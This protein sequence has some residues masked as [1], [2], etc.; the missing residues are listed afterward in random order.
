MIRAAG[1]LL[2]MGACVL[3]LHAE[4]FATLAVTT[5]DARGQVV[6]ANIPVTV[7]RPP[8][9]G[10]FP[11]VILSHGRPPAAQRPR[12]GRVKLSSVATTFLGL[13]MVVIVPTRIGYGAAGGPDVEFSVS[14]EEPK[15]P[16]ALGAVADQIGSA[17]SY[18]RSLSYVDG[19]Q[20]FLVGH[21]VG[22]AG[23]VAAAVRGF[24]GVRAAVNFNGG[25]GG[26][27]GSHPGEPCGTDVLRKTFGDLGGARSTVPL[28]WVHTEN[29]ELISMRYAQEWFAAFT[30]AGGRGTFTAFPAH[31]DGHYWFSA[32]PNSW[33]DAVRAF[34][35]TNGMK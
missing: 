24:P 1:I 18:A 29:D 2:M 35:V 16:E 15:Y 17:V 6:E 10:P 8:G 9:E 7:F 12:M 5:R 27:P 23:T 28:L 33:R 21:S 20:I 31:R 30:V 13:G 32:D 25:H 34:F 19:Q 3:P 22:G 26:R 14:C 4:E 11:A